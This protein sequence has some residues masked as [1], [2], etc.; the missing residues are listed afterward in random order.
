MQVFRVKPT[1]DKTAEMIKP[2]GSFSMAPSL[3]ANDTKVL[4]PDWAKSQNPVV[5]EQHAN[6]VKEL[7]ALPVLRLVQGGR[8]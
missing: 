5:I 6:L 3:S 8:A 4:V 7:R 2:W 1:W